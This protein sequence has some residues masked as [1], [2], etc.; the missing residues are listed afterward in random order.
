MSL[1]HWILR[2]AHWYWHVG[3]LAGDI[4]ARLT[5]T[6]DAKQRL[7][8][9]PGMGLGGGCPPF[10]RRLELGR[11]VGETGSWLKYTRGK[12]K[13]KIRKVQ[14]S[15]GNTVLH[16]NIG[17]MGHDPNIVWQMSNRMMHRNT[18]ESCMLKPTRKESNTFDEIV[19]AFIVHI[20]RVWGFVS[21]MSCE[22]CDV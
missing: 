6:V 9:A 10:W 7:G 20:K 14:K 12:D 18:S 13:I 21:G 8:I 22:Q 19:K 2:F 4:G 16:N 15:A 11:L 3:D 5:C 17:L 1:P